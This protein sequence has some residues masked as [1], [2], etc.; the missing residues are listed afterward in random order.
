[1]HR[2]LA[3]QAEISSPKAERLPT[4]ADDREQQVGGDGNNGHRHRWGVRVAAMN[5]FRFLSTSALPPFLTCSQLVRDGMI[6][7]ALGS[8]PAVYDLSILPMALYTSTTFGLNE[9][10]VPH[11]ESTKIGRGRVLKPCL[12]EP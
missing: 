9:K 6:L 4:Q 5:T 8:F 2:L 11:Q 1:M 7:K 3:Q 12:S 10:N